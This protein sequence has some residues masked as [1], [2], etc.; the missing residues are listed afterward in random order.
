MLGNFAIIR[1]SLP[2]TSP[3]QEYIENVDYAL[4]RAK[5]RSNQLLTFSKGSELIEG[6]ADLNTIKKSVLSNASGSHVKVIFAPQLTELKTVFDTR[7][8]E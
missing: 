4:D 6:N 1:E 8:L 2:Q 3:F 5:Q 7:Q